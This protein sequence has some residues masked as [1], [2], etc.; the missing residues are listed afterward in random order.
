VII[1]STLAEAEYTKLQELGSDNKYAF[2]AEKMWQGEPVELSTYRLQAEKAEYE[3]ALNYLQSQPNQSLELLAPILAD[4]SHS[5]YQKATFSAAYINYVILSDSTAARPYA[6]K[7]S[8]A[9][10]HPFAAELKK[11]YTNDG[12]IIYQ[13]LPALE[14]Y[15]AKLEEEKA[16]EAKAAAE[17]EA[18]ENRPASVMGSGEIAWPTIRDELDTNVII[19]AV[20]IDKSGKVGEIETIQSLKA[21]KPSLDKIAI[22]QV[23]NWEFSPALQD[24]EPVASTL[25][26]SFTYEAKPE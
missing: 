19:L 15:E 4:S 23:K 26:L 13:R 21:D 5:Y 6:E 17:E 22:T 12:F 9:K 25:E 11:F 1:D 3:Q 16:A 14:R 10:D 18:A 7:I 8:A 20:E 2:A 24:G